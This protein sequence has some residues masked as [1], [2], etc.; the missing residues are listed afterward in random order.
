MK[1]AQISEM[2][3]H[4]VK[5]SEIWDSWVVVTL[6]RGIFDLLVSHVILRVIRYTCFQMAFNSNMACRRQIQSK[7]NGS[8]VH[9]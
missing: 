7:K 1:V 2:S 3:N 6:F 5:Q 8:C 4:R 9:L